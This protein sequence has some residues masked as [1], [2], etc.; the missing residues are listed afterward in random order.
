MAS[1]RVKEDEITACY[2][3]GSEIFLVR[4]R[5]K[6]GNIS[7]VNSSSAPKM[8][9]FFQKGSG[10]IFVSFLIAVTKMSQENDFKGERIY[11]SSCFRGVGPSYQEGMLKQ[12][13]L[14]YGSQEIEKGGLDG[15]TRARYSPW[16][17]YLPSA[18]WI[19]S[20]N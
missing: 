3:L 13:S 2:A 6:S 18:Q 12:S 8:A 4:K 16:G 9:S 19:S 11:F 20:S 5:E 17:F 7:G 15:G 1:E 14:C 10:N